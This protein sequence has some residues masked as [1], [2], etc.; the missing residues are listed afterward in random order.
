MAFIFIYLMLHF[1]GYFSHNE[2]SSYLTVI[3]FLLISIA[4][5]LSGCEL[6]ANGVECIGDRLNLSHATAGSLL[7]AVGT[8]MPETLIPILA[9][10]FGKGIHRESIAVGAILGAPFMLAT[11]A[12]FFTGLTSLILYLM[13]KRDKAVHY[14]NLSALKTELLF[15][16]IAMIVILIIS[17]INNSLTDHITAVLLLLTYALFVKITLNHRSEDGEE[18]TEHLHF[19]YIMSCPANNFW[20]T[21]QT[22]TGLA[23]IVV[24]AH[25]F[26]NF[27]TLLSIKSGLSSLVLALL[28]APVASELPEKFNSV[29]WTIKGK[30]TLALS[31]VTGAMV[32]QSTIP[33]SIGLIFTQWHLGHTE[34]LNIAFSLSMA[35]IVYITILTRKKLPS[36][37]LMT[38][39]I[40]YLIYIL[41]IFVFM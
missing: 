2:T 17:Y 22:L 38:G 20:I 9:L 4:V 11:L 13:K 16:I 3:S 35:V 10:I 29:I 37:M 12:F 40:F 39:G 24:G 18:Y 7:A 5:I 41:R 26:I 19:S 6:F 31:N 33:V 15:F 27:L 14:V 28:L 36:F 34:L 1:S 23:L 32:F 30:D 25:I 21:L 8:A